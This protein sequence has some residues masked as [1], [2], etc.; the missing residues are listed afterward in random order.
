VLIYGDLGRSDVV[1]GAGLHFNK[2]EHRP[3]PC[4]QVYIAGQLAR[5]PTPRHQGIALAAQ[6]EE[7]RRL[8]VDAGGQVSR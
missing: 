3:L 6:K 1:G 7:S 5:R 8:A 4:D 2:T